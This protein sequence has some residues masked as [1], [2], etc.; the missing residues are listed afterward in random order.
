MRPR[1]PDDV[2]AV[3]IPPP[4]G[5]TGLAGN[6]ALSLALDEPLLSAKLAAHVSQQLHGVLRFDSAD[7]P[8]D[9]PAP[10][11]SEPAAQGH[12]RAHLIAGA[13]AVREALAD[14]LL[15]QAPYTPIGGAS[16][17]LALEARGPGSAHERQRVYAAALMARHAPTVIDRVAAVAVDHA[18]A[19]ALV[20]DR[21]DLAALGEQIGLRFCGLWFG[22]AAPDHGLLQ[23]AA[24]AGYRALVH[25]IV[26]RHVEPDATVL[27][28]ARAAMAQLTARTATLIARYAELSQVKGEVPGRLPHRRERARWPEHVDPP[29]DWGLSALDP[30]LLKAMALGPDDFSLQELATLATGLV[31]GTVG[32]VQAA[33]CLAMRQLLATPGALAQARELA[34]LPDPGA[35]E[36][37]VAGLLEA[38]PPVAFVPRRAIEA[39]QV[40][41]QP[42]DKDDDVIVWLASAQGAPP[43]G[44]T[45]PLAFGLHPGRHPCVGQQ[46]AFRLIV[47]ALRQLI[48]LPSLAEAIDPVR[49]RPEGLR[50]RWG[51]ACHAYPLMHQRARRLAQQPLNVVM[52]VKAPVEQHAEAIRRVI[53]VGVPRIERALR[54]SGHVHFAW[55]EFLDQ[56]RQLALHTVY[57]G[58]FEAYVEHFALKVDDLFDRLFEHIEGAPPLPV[59]EHPGEFVAVIRAHNAPSVHGY[60]FS[61]YPKSEVSHI[62]GGIVP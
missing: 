51:F 43:T 6:Q 29:S 28:Q 31:V 58:D 18:L 12:R 46:P 5:W 36:R 62:L 2:A 59:A 13:T 8:E 4:G 26:G 15:G 60:F 27:P 9:D 42:I 40:A 44:A 48:A 32:N 47:Q 23:A 17:M 37:H 30:P 10:P 19:V 22:F 57:D 54:E 39:T 34:A 53:A 45:A 25:Q 3:P 38:T 41:G 7:H 21:F 35:F 1:D 56:G 24:A 14:R 52:R 55:F 20:R 50:Q 61:A 49:G 33:L 11:W 16:F